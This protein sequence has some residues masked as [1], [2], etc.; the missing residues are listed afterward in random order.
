M[1][2][3]TTVVN[4]PLFIEVQYDSFKKYMKCDYEFIVFNDSKRFK[5]FSNGNNS[6]T[7]EEIVKTCERLGIRCINLDNADHVEETR[8]SVRT[9][10]ACNSILE[11]QKANKDKYLLLDSDMFLVDYLN[12]EDYFSNYNSA[13]VLQ[14]RLSTDFSPGMGV[15]FGYFNGE[16]DFLEHKCDYVWNGLGYFDFNRLENTELMD[17]NCLDGTDTGGRMWRWLKSQIT[18][19][20]PSCSEIRQTKT[21]FTDEKTYYIRHL[22]SCSWNL[23]ELPENLSE[24]QMLVDFLINDPR[25]SNGNFFCEIYDNKFLH[26]RAGGNWNHEGMKLHLELAKR[27]KSV[28]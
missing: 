5:D 24:N 7:F 16:P 1:K 28:I 13:I 6:N 27:L 12:P 22:W 23:S 25:N 14:T 11:F 15:G 26:Y 8:A 18:K 9:A 4:N 20:S 3:V 10:T 19:D 17:W 2:V 21:N